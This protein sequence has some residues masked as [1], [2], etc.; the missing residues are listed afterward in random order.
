MMIKKTLLL[1]IL[2]VS[3]LFLVSCNVEETSGESVEIV[4]E[5]GNIVGEATRFSTGVYKLR[6]K[7]V[8]MLN[9]LIYSY[10]PKKL[11]SLIFI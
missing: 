5:Q 4:N 9:H 3:L 6:T 11:R 7:P 8:V 10:Y 2:L 1:S